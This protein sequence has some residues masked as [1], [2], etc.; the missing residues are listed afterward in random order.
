MK[1]VKEKRFAGPFREIPFEHFIQSPIGMVPK[2][3][4]KDYRLI[5]HLSYPKRGNTVNANTP[6]EICLVKYPDFSSAIK[7]CLQEG[8][9]CKIGRSDMKA[10]FCGL[11]MLRKHLKYLVMKARS[12][13]DGKTYYFFN[14]ALPF[15]SSISCSHFQHF[16]NAIVY[17]LKYCM[18]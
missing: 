1:E 15:G 6:Q 2:Y 7:R 13:L 10:A 4:G 5:F 3:G 17:I 11:G 18:R 12:P 16:S 14:K 9:G 8:P